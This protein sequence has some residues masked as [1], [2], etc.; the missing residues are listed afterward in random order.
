MGAL[1]LGA[2]QLGI[3]A[4]PMEGLVAERIDEEFG[5]REKGYTT[6]GAVS[7]GYRS[8]EDYN[9]DLPKSRL[10]KETVFSKA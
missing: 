9:A 6:I 2:A 3:D 10:P 5:L 1:L 4:V 8:D 7:L